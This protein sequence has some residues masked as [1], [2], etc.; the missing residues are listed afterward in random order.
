[1]PL[2]PGPSKG[3]PGTQRNF[4]DLDAGQ[5]NR[6]PQRGMGR[7]RNSARS[8]KCAGRRYEIL[9]VHSNETPARVEST[10]ADA[11]DLLSVRAIAS[12]MAVRVALDT[13]TGCA[14]GSHAPHDIQGAPT[15]RGSLGRC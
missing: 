11:P 6:C 10:A 14:T 13:S 15:Y 12:C 1:M 9:G 4:S 5:E 2:S 3:C 8:L 7:G